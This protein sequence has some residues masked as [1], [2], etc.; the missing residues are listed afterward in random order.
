[1]FD[2]AFL[3]GVGTEEESS[4][5][6]LMAT[7]DDDE[8][9]DLGGQHN[10]PRTAS[11]PS[12][13]A[14]Y[15]E[16]QAG[17]LVS[18][19]SAGRR[20]KAG[21]QSPSALYDHLTSVEGRS[22]KQKP[23]PRSVYSH[24][25]SQMPETLTSLEM[26]RR[27][28]AES[29]EH[30]A[31]ERPNG[32]YAALIKRRTPRTINERER[33]TYSTIIGE[34]ESDDDSEGNQS[35]RPSD[36]SVYSHVSRAHRKSAHSNFDEEDEGS[37]AGLSPS[38]PRRHS[39]YAGSFGMEGPPSPNPKSVSDAADCSQSSL[40]R[41]TQDK[42][43]KIFGAGGAVV[44]DIDAAAQAI[45]NE[46]YD[47][48]DVA[49]D[50]PAPCER[51]PRARDTNLDTGLTMRGKR[52]SASKS[53]DWDDTLSYSK[54]AAFS[55]GRKPSKP[56]PT[57]V[58]DFNTTQASETSVDSH[59]VQLTSPDAPPTATNSRPR[60]SP[61]SNQQAGEIQHRSP[62]VSRGVRK[63]RTSSLMVAEHQ[64]VTSIDDL[65]K[66][67]AG[68]HTRVLPGRKGKRGGASSLLLARPSKSTAD[69]LETDLDTG[70]TFATARA[71]SAALNGKAQA[72][73]VDSVLALG[74][75]SSGS[76]HDDEEIC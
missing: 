24:I 15:K 52:R 46:I 11:K 9:S 31:V 32:H 75:N 10:T 7:G 41:D 64:S 53:L 4:D 23:G 58:F 16:A 71:T 17:D 51:I 42:S 54:S 59:M 56:S 66:P 72:T 67:K 70:L 63:V 43:V 8:T 65:L 61:R 2:A 12:P 22:K 48:E 14:M 57:L 33:N 27:W 21:K 68:V 19:G 76:R 45:A 6:Y 29:A 25:T 73:S 3:C 39:D 26:A 1:M 62:L 36:D 38:M 34:E 40:S 47:N 55:K 28:S 74:R 18:K 35:V 13:R 30:D 44:Y 49:T 69:E 50:V 60:P 37:T 20:S 5:V